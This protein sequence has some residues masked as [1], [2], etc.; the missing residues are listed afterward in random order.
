MTINSEITTDAET[1]TK[2]IVI[3]EII[4]DAMSRI[5]VITGNKIITDVE[6]NMKIIVVNEIT[7]EMSIITVVMNPTIVITG[8]EIGIE[9]NS[10]FVATVS[11][12]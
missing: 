7:E 6:T 2:I 1:D 5:I 10:V 8:N 9:G 4:I 12:N 3:V 11:T